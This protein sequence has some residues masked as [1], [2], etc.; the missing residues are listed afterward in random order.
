MLVEFGSVFVL[1]RRLWASLR[2]EGMIINK[3][4]VWR[5]MH[6]RHLT[7]PKIWH[8]PYYPKQ[9]GKIKPVGTNQNRQIDMTSFTLTDLTGLYL[10]TVTN[11]YTR[12]TV[13][14]T[15]YRYCRTDELIGA[16]RIALDSDGRIT[17]EVCRVPWQDKRTR[18]I[19]G[20]QFTG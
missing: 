9:I 11:C 17:K 2:C 1:Y 19:Y 7:L 10:V 8:K 15:L 20:L 14:W 3:K 4:T 12:K 13:G 18:T 5:N 16:L 6:E